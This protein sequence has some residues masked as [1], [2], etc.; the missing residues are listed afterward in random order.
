[1]VSTVS[2]KWQIGQQCDRNYWWQNLSGPVR[3][4]DALSELIANNY[5]TF[6]EVGPEPVLSRSIEELLRI[7][8]RRGLVL[9]SIRR[10][11]NE[12]ETMLG[13]LTTL[14]AQKPE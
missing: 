5:C 12:R 14:R 1:M 2:G 3:F 4:P 7:H 13:S 11:A 6:L 9:P 8:R 10:R